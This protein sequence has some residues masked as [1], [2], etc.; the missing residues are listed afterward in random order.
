M[1]ATAVDLGR[2]CH[3]KLQLQGTILVPNRS[4]IKQGSDIL[5]IAA[6]ED[7]LAELLQ[8]DKQHTERIDSIW[9]ASV[10]RQGIPYYQARFSR[11][12]QNGNI[13]VV[14]VCAA[15]P[16]YMGKEY[17]VLYASALAAELT[18]QVISM[19]G[20]AAAHRSRK[21]PIKLGDVLV[22]T[23]TVALEE[24]K[25]EGP[26]RKESGQ[27][28]SRKSSAELIAHA[29]LP[30]RS[31]IELEKCFPQLLTEEIGPRTDYPSII[32]TTIRTVDEVRADFDDGLEHVLRKTKGI[33]MEAHGLLTVAE[34][35]DIPGIVI[36]G[37]QDYATT[38]SKASDKYRRF[39]ASASAYLTLYSTIRFCAFRQPDSVAVCKFAVRK[40]AEQ[41][42]YILPN[43]LH[44]GQHYEVVLDDEHRQLQVEGEVLVEDGAELH[45]RGTGEIVLDSGSRVVARGKLV[46][47]GSSRGAIEV[48]SKSHLA[49]WRAIVLVGAGAAGSR[50]ENVVFSG[51][52]GCTV[53]RQHPMYS[54]AES[55]YAPPRVR[56]MPTFDSTQHQSGGAVAIL[57]TNDVEVKTC[58]FDGNSANEGGA[59]SIISSKN[60]RFVG[61]FFTG[62]AASG[63]HNNSAPGGAI[64]CQTS[65]DVTFRGCVFEA[66]RAKDSSSCGG[67]LYVG[68]NSYVRVSRCEFQGN[69]AENAGGA[70]YIMGFP[71]NVD[72]LSLPAPS[73]LEVYNGNVF[74]DNSAPGGD[75]IR[76]DFGS[77]VGI[78]A[79]YTTSRPGRSSI[80]LG[81]AGPVTSGIDNRPRVNIHRNRGLTIE[82]MH[83]KSIR[84]EDPDGAVLQG[85]GKKP[86]KKRSVKKKKKKKTTKR[87]AAKTPAAKKSNKRPIGKKPVKKKSAKKKTTKRTPKKRQD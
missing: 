3:S 19:C 48:K 36:K 62:N 9:T 39:S 32:P 42:S 26:S 1:I 65:S 33:E 21:N 4:N 47:H 43:V 50:F 6:L 61:C 2:Q 18:P 76:V 67:A 34:F 73:I 87:T 22:A 37:V 10:T 28:R 16:Q 82:G 56:L 72:G 86:A 44:E 77:H 20:V 64:F 84:L 5:I 59:T 41:K 68:M 31:D 83:G 25:V 53:E 7:E 85:Q 15:S 12:Q 54:A 75:D 81:D 49:K 51:G 45:V 17:S 55:V 52:A 27:I 30:K 74:K 38:K 80:V 70:V 14:R 69:Q 71:I 79:M 57:E 29:L 66:N 11:R 46:I 60:I 8:T 24:K 58:D 78:D 23:D 63:S 40:A 35:F 13:R